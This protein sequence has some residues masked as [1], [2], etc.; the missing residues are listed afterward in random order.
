MSLALRGVATF[1]AFALGLARAF[2]QPVDP[3]QLAEVFDRVV[4]SNPASEAVRHRLLRARSKGVRISLD[5]SV[6]A[7]PEY[8]AL[9]VA[10]A[11]QITQLTDVPVSVEFGGADGDVRIFLEEPKHWYL[12]FQHLG[13]DVEV[14]E[15]QL[16]NF[17][18]GSPRPCLSLLRRNDKRFA[19]TGGALL[20]DPD[21]PD[22]SVRYCIVKELLGHFGLLSDFDGDD[23]AGRLDTV[24]DV[25]QKPSVSGVL[26]F[27]AEMLRVLYSDCLRSGMS[28][29]QVLK[30]I[31][32]CHYGQTQ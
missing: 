18:D 28:R 15:A 2:A 14:T 31:Q 9:V 29:H 6:L 22:S 13:Y 7:M 1:I 30:Q 32:N 25:N 12:I 27:D 21:Q 10:V 20:L 26:P 19:L 8:Q 3:Q 4:F 23:L 24:F 5:D 17:P 11:D 16:V